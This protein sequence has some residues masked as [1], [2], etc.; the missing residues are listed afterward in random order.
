M[1][2]NKKEI[3]GKRAVKA[4]TV[5]KDPVVNKKTREEIE[6]MFSFGFGCDCSSCS[7]HC[8]DR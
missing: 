4:K 5:K 2:N 3:S 1:I 7:H 8:G 6:E